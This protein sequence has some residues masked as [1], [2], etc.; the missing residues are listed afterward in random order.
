MPTGKKLTDPSI[1]TGTVLD[2]LDVSHIVDKSDTTDGPAGTSKRYPWST[3]FTW[4]LGKLN[5]AFLL[6]P[7]GGTTGQALSKASNT[8]FDVVWTNPAATVSVTA[9]ITGDGSGGSP[10]AL[11]VDSTPTDGSSNLVSSNGVFDA[12]AASVNANAATV[13]NITYAALT[14]AVSAGTL[15]PK[16]QYR[17]TDA[18]DGIVRVWGVSASTLSASAFLEGLSDN[19]NYFPG[20][21]GNYDVGADIFTGDL[22]TQTNTT[23]A[24][25]ITDE[26]YGTFTIT[27]FIIDSVG[28]VATFSFAGRFDLD[29]LQTSGTCKF[30]LPAA[31]Q[32]TANWA[33]QTDVNVAMSRT[34]DIFTVNTFIAA[35]D[36][37]TKL[38]QVS[39]SDV[40][41]GSSVRFSAVGRYKI[42]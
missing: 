3:I 14:A 34:N 10:L 31:F 8:S 22:A 28:D 39:V 13:I 27:N 33:S 9:P 21:W 17:V 19:S 40:L 20:A 18:A 2:D 41:A 36:S 16:A 32:P 42:A 7:S 38:L 11:T 25:T 1:P 23:F 15:I 30:N 12:I 37:G 4:I 26:S 29:A 6:I 35:D 24:P 5:A